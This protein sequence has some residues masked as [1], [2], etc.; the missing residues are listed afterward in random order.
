[1]MVIYRNHIFILK[2]I[3]YEKNSK[4]Y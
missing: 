3:N 1:M 2:E 4:T